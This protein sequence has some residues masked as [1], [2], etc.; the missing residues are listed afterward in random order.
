VEGIHEHALAPTDER[1]DRMEPAL[2][3][4]RALAGYD[5]GC[6]EGGMGVPDL[7]GEPHE[8]RLTTVRCPTGEPHL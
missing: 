3:P 7:A 4:R 8:R 5:P 2:V 6:K 1:V